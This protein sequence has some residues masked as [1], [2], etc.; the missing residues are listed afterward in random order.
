MIVTRSWFE[1]SDNIYNSLSSIRSIYLKLARFKTPEL[2]PY[3]GD[4]LFAT[5]C[6]NCHHPVANSDF[7]FTQPIQH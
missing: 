4:A 5:E 1:L 2:K 6:I 7:V 3:G